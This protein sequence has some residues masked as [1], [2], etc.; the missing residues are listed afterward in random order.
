MYENFSIKEISDLFNSKTNMAISL[1]KSVIRD[2]YDIKPDLYRGGICCISTFRGE[3]DYSFTIPFEYCENEEKVKDFYNRLLEFTKDAGT[4]P[5]KDDLCTQF[6]DLE[7][8]KLM[9]IKS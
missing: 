8:K 7:F 4:I 6:T 3:Y 1:V 5:E 2:Y 9:E